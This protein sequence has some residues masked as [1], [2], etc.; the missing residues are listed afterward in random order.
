MQ[1]QEGSAARERG[2]NK[3]RVG[4]V[5]STAM[6]KTIT[7]SV[8]RLV[9]HPLYK[10]AIKRTKKFRAH[11]KD[12]VCKVGDMVRIRETRPLS[13]T[14]RWRMVEIVKKAD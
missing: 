12:N 10:K 6:D 9:E 7:V 1:N 3:E 13:K 4:V 2:E 5:T 8:M 11:D 14:K